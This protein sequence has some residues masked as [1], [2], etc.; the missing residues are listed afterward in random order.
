MMTPQKKTGIILVGIAAAM[1]GLSFAAVPFYDW[2]CRTTGF[3]GTTQVAAKPS[4]VM[5]DKKIT[6]WFDAS[7]EAG[8]PWT[9][10]AEA[11]SMELKIGENGLA[12]YRAHNPTNRIVA[13]TASYNV[14]PD[15]AGAYFTKV[16]CFCFTQQVL[17]HGETVDMPVSFYVDPEIVNDAE[18]K[19]VHEITLSYTFHETDLPEEQA[20]LAPG[21]SG[22]SN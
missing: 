22:A 14:S 10:K 5:L 4:D 3:A 6:V 19:Y 20:A 8:M 9:F 13:G 2:F 1:L 21:L 12:F 11:P 7:K 16:A 18:A 15:S 17:Q